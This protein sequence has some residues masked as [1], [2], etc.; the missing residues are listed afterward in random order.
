MVLPSS[1]ATTPTTGSEWHGPEGI[2]I[3]RS[4]RRCLLLQAGCMPYLEAWQWQREL[5]AQRS[6]GD[7]GD[8]LLLL[9]HPP[10]ITL[11]RAAHRKHLLVP[12]E[13]LARRGVAL[14]ES[15]R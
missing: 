13:E 12:P 7:A 8:T 9:Q 14:V 6:S 2:D 5:V 15:D 3:T 4:L 1:S 11:G 10:T